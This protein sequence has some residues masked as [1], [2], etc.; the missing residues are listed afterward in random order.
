MVIDTHQDLIGHDAPVMSRILPAHSEY[1]A[2]EGH[3]KEDVSP[4]RSRI[5]PSPILLKEVTAAKDPC[6]LVDFLVAE[7][8]IKR[9]ITAL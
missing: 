5:P 4:V 3:E 2:F 9:R 1:S 8:P 6:S 7:L